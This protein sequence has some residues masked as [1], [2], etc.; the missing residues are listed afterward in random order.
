[1]EFSAC[2]IGEILKQRWLE[3]LRGMHSKTSTV[4]SKVLMFCCVPEMFAK[5][6]PAAVL[7]H[8]MDMLYGTQVSI[9][10]MIF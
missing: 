6:K 2:F 3:I 7:L 9:G 10:M 4:I 8:I 1:V 5:R